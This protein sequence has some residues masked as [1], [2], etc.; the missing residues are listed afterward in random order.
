[1]A[2]SADSNDIKMLYTHPGHSFAR[3]PEMIGFDSTKSAMMIKF[4]HE[5]T[6]GSQQSPVDHAGFEDVYVV[7]HDPSSD[8]DRVPYN[9]T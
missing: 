2:P 9:T 8:V 5:K 6:G 3:I 4:V 1:V 7:N